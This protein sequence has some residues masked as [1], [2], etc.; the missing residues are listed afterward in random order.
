MEDDVF[1]ISMN[2]KSGHEEI[3]HESLHMAYYI[4][5][6]VGIKHDVNNHE[7]LC[8]LQGY[9]AKQIKKYL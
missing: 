4:L 7:V 2:E 5:E 3:Y 8:Y 6:S 1:I 9:I